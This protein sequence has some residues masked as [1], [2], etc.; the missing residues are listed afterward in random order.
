MTKTFGSTP[1]FV[2]VYLVFMIPTYLLPYLGSNSAVLGAAAAAADA[3]VNPAF[4][5]HLIC[6]VVLLDVTS[7]RG[8]FIGKKW[9]VIF[10]VIAIVFEFIPGLNWIP[11]V[12]TAMHLSALIIG[13]KGADTPQRVVVEE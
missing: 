6:L 2:I 10:P 5:V 12:P 13:A 3:G 1:V 11:L 9:I 7:Y 8:R 4:W